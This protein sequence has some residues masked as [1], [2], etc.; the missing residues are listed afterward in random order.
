VTVFRDDVY[1]DP[2]LLGSLVGAL[3]AWQ[4]LVAEAEPA[5]PRCVTFAF[6]GTSEAGA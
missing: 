5:R 6:S 3:R 4:G 1:E 2:H